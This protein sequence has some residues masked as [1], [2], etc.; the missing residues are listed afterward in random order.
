MYYGI[1]RR[2]YQTYVLT[3]IEFNSLHEVITKTFNL[4]SVTVEEKNL[5]SR[6]QIRKDNEEK[7]YQNRLYIKISSNV[8][9]KLWKALQF[10]NKMHINLTL[11]IN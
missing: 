4:Y 10:Y 7:Y 11:R 1:V 2:R 5:P 6:T 3:V 8:K 9:N